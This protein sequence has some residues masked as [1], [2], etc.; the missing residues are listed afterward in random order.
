MEEEKNQHRVEAEQ[1]KLP[2]VAKVQLQRYDD[3]TESGGK[4]AHSGDSH[5]RMLVVYVE[6]E[7]QIKA[8]QRGEKMKKPTTLMETGL[9]ASLNKAG[10]KRLSSGQKGSSIA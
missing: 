7:I 6:K 4:R 8:I 9:L 1:V 10:I 2:C 5:M 3:G